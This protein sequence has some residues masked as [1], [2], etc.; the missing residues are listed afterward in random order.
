[1]IGPTPCLEVATLGRFELRRN[2]DPLSRAGAGFSRRERERID[3]C[4]P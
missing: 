1:M 2:S 4:S 3:V